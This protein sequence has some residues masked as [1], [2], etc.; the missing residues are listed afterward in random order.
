LEFR[1]IIKKRVNRGKVL[2]NIYIEKSG[3]DNKVAAIEEENLTSL[4]N[5]LKI[6]K[7]KAG[8]SEEITLSNL[9]EFQN[10]IFS[11]SL[12][13]NSKEFDATCKALEIALENLNKMRADEGKSLVDDLKY[14]VG[15][16]SESV[17]KVSDTQRSVIN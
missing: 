9:L 2:V 7:E 13:D 6:I 4:I 17:Q 16:I 11:D 3:L 8:I 15:L 12:E 1:N 14:R 10:V 5:S